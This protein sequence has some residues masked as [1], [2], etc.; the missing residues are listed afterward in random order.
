MT[1]NLTLRKT[2]QACKQA[3]NCYKRKDTII[4]NRAAKPAQ[5]PQ[6]QAGITK[7]R[8]QQTKANIYQRANN[9]RAGSH[10]KS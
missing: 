8:Q 3:F 7:L 2:S 1:C 4:A 5:T 10:H 9:I 6:I